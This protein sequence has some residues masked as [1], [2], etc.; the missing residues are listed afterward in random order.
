[1]GDININVNQTQSQNQHQNTYSFDFDALVKDLDSLRSALK[2]SAD[3]DNEEHD[4]AIG[5]VVSAKKAAQEKD[6][7]KTLACLEEV[8]KY[9]WVLNIVKTAGLSVVT[10]AITKI[11]GLS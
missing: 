7:G 6:E 3:K 10:A 5:D 4:A 11:S 2:K 9:K 8:S 1:M